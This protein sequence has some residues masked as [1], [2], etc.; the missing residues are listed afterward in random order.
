MQGVCAAIQRRG[1]RRCGVSLN[2]D[3]AADSS[4][5][6]QI[7]QV[8]WGKSINLHQMTLPCLLFYHTWIDLYN[9][10]SLL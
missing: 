2:D 1:G 4:A 8:Y 5:L 9:N 6:M 10:F 3:N 7:S